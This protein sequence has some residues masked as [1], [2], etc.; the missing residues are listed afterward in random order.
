MIEYKGSLGKLGIGLPLASLFGGMDRLWRAI[1]LDAGNTAGTLVVGEAKLTKLFENSNHPERGYG[2]Q[3]RAS[4]QSETDLHKTGSVTT[5]WPGM[6]YGVYVHDGT[7]DRSKTSAKRGDKP[8]GPNDSRFIF[9]KHTKALR[10]FV[11]NEEFMRPYVRKGY[12][13]PR[14][15]LTKALDDKSKEVYQVFADAV[16]LLATTIG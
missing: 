15:F 14:P 8:T 4:I 11:N 9:P 10:F 13:T 16:H 12:R 5:V 2:G 7:V 3:L 6:D 1:L